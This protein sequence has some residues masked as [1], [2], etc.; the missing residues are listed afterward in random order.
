MQ[1]SIDKR[2]HFLSDGRCPSSVIVAVMVINFFIKTMRRLH[3]LIFRDVFGKLLIG[4]QMRAYE[5]IVLIADAY[6]SHR[7]FENDGFVIGVE[8]RVVVVII[9]KM[10][11]L[12]YSVE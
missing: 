10:I 5:A 9:K 7:R 2:V 12:G 3:V 11:V 4:S 6:L 1:N 8:Y